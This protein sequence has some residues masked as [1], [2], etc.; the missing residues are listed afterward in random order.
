MPGRAAALSLL[1]LSLSLMVSGVSQAQQPEEIPVAINGM[2][3]VNE[4][5]NGRFSVAIQFPLQ[6]HYVRAKRLYPNLYVLFRD[7]GVNRSQFDIPRE[8]VQFETDDVSRTI[9]FKGDVLGI[10]ANRN[11]T[12]RLMLPQ[13]EKI[14]TRVE[15]RIFTTAIYRPGNGLFITLKNE[16]RLPAAARVIEY[17]PDR[18]HL[19]YSLPERK[20]EGTP[21][22]DVNLRVKKRL[23]G[24]LYKI[25][26][27]PEAGYGAFWM[28][29]TVFKNVGNV[30]IYD[31]AITYRLGEYTDQSVPEKYT[32]VPAG[33]AVV[34]VYY[35][36][37]SSRAAQLK[38]RTPTELRIKYEYRDA[39]GRR[40]TDER[41]ERVEIL[42]V[43]Q[44]EFSNLSDEDRT[45]SWFDSFN[46][47]PLTAAFVTKNC[48]AVRQF[49]GI[50]SDAAGGV[51]AARSD[52]EARRWLKAAYDQQM[53][54]NIVY[55]TPSGFLTPE[56][57]IAQDLKYPR[58][59]FRDKAGTCID[60]AITYAALAESV[61]LRSYLLLMP[62]H[63]FAIIRLPSGYPL[64]IENTGL[65]GDANR[66]SFEKALEEGAR[67]LAEA[68]ES[69]V[70][71]L[72]DVQKELSEGRVT[73]PELPMLPPDYLE[74]CGIKRRR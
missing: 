60:L 45:D 27:D 30:P 1:L 73:N 34:D 48:E 66:W 72:I 74:K 52:Q 38:T 51:A 53:V 42:G 58:D 71:Y 21:K 63:C 69:G 14:I 12:W 11:N 35:P 20:V 49:S 10:A 9:T 8:G 62:G 47:A 33:G 23:M 65:G 41:A 29:K 18:Q 4:V 13:E 7:Y 55:Q 32:L 67:K 24:A 46:N 26:S 36:I 59:V 37:L 50:V 17:A 19:T 16:Y 43:N 15:N 54:N 39:S 28:A 56:R 6:R 70:F 57:S 64:A 3:Y 40:Y 2:L 44:F 61:G 25:Y 31:L 5:G 68:Q 22:V